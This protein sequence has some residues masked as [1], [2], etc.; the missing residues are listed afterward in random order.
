MIGIILMSHGELAEG[1]LDT[2][3]LFFGDDIAQIKAL[4][5]KSGDNPEEFDL[6]I[7]EAVE[8]VDSGAGVVAFCD[9]LFGT[10]CNRTFYI[11][12]DRL[13]VVTGMNL[14]VVMELLG[15]RETYDDNHITV[16]NIN[17]EELIETGKNGMVSFNKMAKEMGI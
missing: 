5:L 14:P 4:C 12:N 15:K 13:Q 6:R 11:L 16:D 1:L 8:E 7:K 17:L 2:C 9:L 3:K 10:P